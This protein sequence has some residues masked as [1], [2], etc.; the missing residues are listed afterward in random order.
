MY[1]LIDVLTKTSIVEFY[2]KNILS[3]LLSVT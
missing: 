3:A 2:V 1:L